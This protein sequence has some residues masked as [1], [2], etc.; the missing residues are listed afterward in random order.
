LKINKNVIHIKVKIMSLLLQTYL[1]ESMLVV[2][3]RLTPKALD[4]NL[5]SLAGTA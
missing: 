2:L 4:D 5:S 3:F 1:K